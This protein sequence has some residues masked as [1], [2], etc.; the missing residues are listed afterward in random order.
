MTMT[1]TKENRLSENPLFIDLPKDKLAEIALDAE[2]EVVPAHTS[3]FREGDPGDRFYIINSGKVRLFKRGRGGVEIPL[4]EL[5]PGEFFGQVAILTEELRWMNVETEEKTHLTIIHKDRLEKILKNYPNVSL[6]FAKQ[7]SRC[8]ARDDLIIKKKSLRAKEGPRAS[9]LDFFA[10]FFLSLLGGIIFNYSNPN[11]INLIPK[12]MTH[13]EIITVTPSQAFVYHSDGAALFVDARPSTLYQQG[14]I[15]G[16]INI[17]LPLFDIMYMMK[18][19][20]PDKKRNIIVYGRTISSLYDEQAARKL[21]LRGHENIMVLKGGLTL[22]KK[23]GYPV[24]P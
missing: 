14:H 23:K 8:L 16:A 5:G 1:A 4:A 7:M 19:S 11:G 3:I 22:W 20:E 2:D 9:W 10:I 15:E 6:A 12:F 17:P 21:A 24:A 13:E 18:F